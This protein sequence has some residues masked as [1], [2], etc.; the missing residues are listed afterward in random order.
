M[1]IRRRIS[2]PW[3]RRDD[4]RLLH[5]ALLRLLLMKTNHQ[6]PVIEGYIT[7]PPNL[8]LLGLLL[9]DTKFCQ[10]VCAIFMKQN[11][12]RGPRQYSRDCRLAI[13]LV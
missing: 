7:H 5:P 6:E 8:S 4:P 2:R 9:L 1:R 12:Y 10:E 13:V 3:G 11:A